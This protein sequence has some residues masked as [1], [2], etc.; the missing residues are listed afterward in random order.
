MAAQR[1]PAAGAETEPS[2]AQATQAEGPRE[3]PSLETPSEDELGYEAARDALADVVRRLEA[4][5]LTLEDSLTLW[6]SG[7]ALADVCQRR[8]DGARARL[9]AALEEPGRRAGG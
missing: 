3:T 7:E 6:E 8:L 5:N 1:K 2:A 4:G 9:A